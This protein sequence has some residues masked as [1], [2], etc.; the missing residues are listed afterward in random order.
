MNFYGLGVKYGKVDDKSSDFFK[1]N[2]WTTGWKADDKK[3][4]Q[5][6]ILDAAVGDIVFVKS[7]TQYYP[8]K[9]HIKAFGIIKSKVLPENIPE[10]YKGSMGFEIVWLKVLDE[11]YI[12]ET[13]NSLM[14][15][16]TDRLNS[17]YI[18]TDEKL[19][20]E[21]WNLLDYKK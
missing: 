11:D 14:P 10:E 15:N 3:E 19:K 12:Y 21:L 5:K 2:F 18:E 1:Y 13:G 20:E 7:F 8:E 9:M 16:H 17:I 4:Y 6:L